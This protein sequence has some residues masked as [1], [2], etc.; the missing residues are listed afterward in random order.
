MGFLSS[1]P[2][3]Y[4]ILGKRKLAARAKNLEIHFMG[5]LVCYLT[6]I[7]P[8]LPKHTK[9]E[10]A[11]QGKT[12]QGG[13]WPQDRQEEQSPST[14]GLVAVGAS[15]NSLGKATKHTW[16]C[17]R[18]PVTKAQWQET[19]AE[20]GLPITWVQGPSRGH[21]QGLGYQG[22]EVER[23]GLSFAEAPGPMGGRHGWRS[24]LRM[25]RAIKACLVSSEPCHHSYLQ[26]R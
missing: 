25:L 6:Y 20:T 9:N 1:H 24:Q 22:P 18:H 23:W 16:G 4:N 19:R 12:S 3:P 7:R 8:L 21:G 17:P 13:M 11:P 10:T 26:K 14:A 2:H 5:S 15:L